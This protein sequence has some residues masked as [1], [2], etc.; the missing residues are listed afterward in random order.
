MLPRGLPRDAVTFVGAAGGD[1]EP[2]VALA[3]G[4]SGAFSTCI[5]ARRLGSRNRVVI[6]CANTHAGI[7][8]GG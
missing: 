8:V 3:S 7:G 5:W 6:R 2:A 4:E 1:S